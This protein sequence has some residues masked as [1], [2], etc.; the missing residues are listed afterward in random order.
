MVPVSRTSTAMSQPESVGTMI[1]GG[2]PAG[3]GAAPTGKSKMTE[4][5]LKQSLEL[6]VSVNVR[7]L[8]PGDN[9]AVMLYAL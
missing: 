5:R 7:L 8:M 4:I 3:G 2:G 9:S 1:G 6:P